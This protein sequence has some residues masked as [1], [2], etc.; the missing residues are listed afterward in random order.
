MEDLISLFS[1]SSCITTYQVLKF[2]K[3]KT[4]RRL[5][6]SLDIV[7]GSKLIISEA[8]SPRGFRYAYHWQTAFNKLLARWDNAPHHSH[9]PIFPAHFHEGHIVRAASQ[10]TIRDVFEYIFKHL[11]T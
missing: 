2:E 3:T 4:T 6:I 5:K 10:P 9:L 11:E 1:E 7:D 8:T